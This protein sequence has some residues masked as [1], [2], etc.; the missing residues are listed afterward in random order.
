[1]QKV[2]SAGYNGQQANVIAATAVLTLCPDM[3]EDTKKSKS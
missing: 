2:Q 1:V 3:N